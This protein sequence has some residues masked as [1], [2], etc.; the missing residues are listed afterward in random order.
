MPDATAPGEQ[1]HSAIVKALR[2]SCLFVLGSQRR[3]AGD[4]A[5]PQTDK[6]RQ[7][8]VVHARRREQRCRKNTT[9]RSYT[10]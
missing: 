3:R 8:P 2:Q 6:T 5:V 10:E 4:T 1:G 7:F 9:G